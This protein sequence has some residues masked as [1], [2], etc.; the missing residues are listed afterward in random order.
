MKRVVG[1]CFA[2]I[3]GSSALGACSS[4][5]DV[6]L[7]AIAE[8]SAKVADA[9]EPT[10]STSAALSHLE[11]ASGAR[12]SLLAG[13]NGVGVRHLAGVSKPIMTDGITAEAATLRF[14][15]DNKDLFAIGDAA[16]ELTLLKSTTTPHLGLAHARFKQTTRGVEV[17]GRE[18]IAHFDSAGSLTS[19]STDYAP[20][21][22]AV[23]V[24]PSLTPAD[25][26]AKAE[27]H[28]ATM[29]DGFDPAKASSP[30]KTKLVVYVDDAGAGHLAWQTELFAVRVAN[31][32]STMPV[33]LIDAMN[34]AVLLSYENLQAASVAVTLP[35]TNVSRNVKITQAASGWTMVDDSRTTGK[36]STRN[37]NYATSTSTNLA[38]VSSTS[39]SSGWDAA[40]VDAQFGAEEV[41]DF[42]KSSFGRDSWD[43]GNG[44]LTSYIHVGDS[45][46]N[47]TA[48]RKKLNNAFWDGQ[49]MNYGDGDGLLLT[50]LSAGLDVCAHE[51]THGVTSAESNLAYQG[52]SGALNES[53]SDIFGA[54]VEHAVDPNL[55]HNAAIG[56][57]VVGSTFPG[58]ALR[59][60]DKPAN[61]D[62]AQ[63][64]TYKGTNWASTTGSDS[65]GVHTNSG[66][67]NNAFWIMT[68]ASK[69]PVT[70]I[71]PSTAISWANSAKLW[72]TINTTYLRSSSKMADEA[73]ATADAA[74]ALNFSQADKNI[75]EC[76]WIAVRVLTGTCKDTTGG[77]ST[78]AGSTT[79]A[80]TTTGGGSTTGGKT[81]TGGSSTT[82][83]G[84]KADA[85]VKTD[86][87]VKGTGA[88]SDAGAGQNDDLTTGT[89]TASG[90]GCK[91][92]GSSSNAPTGNA[93]VYA[94]FGLMGLAM[95]RRRR[96]ARKG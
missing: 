20:G 33:A 21:L 12:W 31:T 39:Q 61:G 76:A 87:G 25:A 68:T 89:D 46:A 71:G 23:G 4:D 45:Q 59:F 66:V 90:C 53:M 79:G 47:T 14:V 95:L 54:L 83:G 13:E 11:Q 27:A 17:W 85:G 40:G 91:T 74:T 2:A 7:T 82:G 93:P 92:A 22:D 48:G 8:P 24:T 69:N 62:P 49:A 28:A 36:I 44:P 65:G 56:E 94:G 88:T 75:I 50:K 9:P 67:P 5:D 84:T 35:G 18:L 37:A 43:N 30:A 15:Q 80:G 77:S 60:M 86:G 38:L 6:T 42:Y 10:A 52:E 51:L 29:G 78:T 34:G 32:S 19:L 73:K 70:N 16:G 96:N 72:Y 64:S 58:T 26:I 81:T 3:V 41:Y 1:L 57:D 55:T 63:P